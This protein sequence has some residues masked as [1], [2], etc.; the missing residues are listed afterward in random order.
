MKR[1]CLVLMLCCTLTGCA[2]LAHLDEL[3]RLKD[4]SDNRDGQA[5]YVEKRDKDFEKLLTVVKANTLDRFYDQASFLKEFGPP[6][7][8]REVTRDGQ[9]LEQWLYRYTVR[10]FESPKIYVYFNRSN[11]IVLWEY[12][13]RDNPGNSSTVI[14]R[15][16]P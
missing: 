6:L 15:T 12:Y 16:I 11:R 10:A 13:P 7:L 2:K 9:P 1:Y 8:R 14:Q 5:V 4:L 3:L